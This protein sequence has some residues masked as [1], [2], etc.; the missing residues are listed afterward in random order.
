MAPIDV[1]D[2]GADEVKSAT[3]SRR[4]HDYGAIDGKFTVSW[5]SSVQYLVKR[6]LEKMPATA[7]MSSERALRERRHAPRRRGVLSGM[8][9]HGPAFFTS[10]CA[11]LDVSLSGARVRVPAAEPLGE[12]MYLLDFSHGLAFEAHIAWRRQDR[13]GLRFKTYYDLSE[14]NS[15]GPTLL[16][17]LWIDRL[18]R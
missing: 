9:V 13:V 5:D 2:H 14:P 17:R 18:S 10:T 12:P 8:L 15:G 7:L 4:A 11:I 6:S 1:A 16:R 3:S